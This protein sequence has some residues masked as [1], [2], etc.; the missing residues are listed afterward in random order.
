MP[1]E[2]Q[3]KSREIESQIFSN[4]QEKTIQLVAENKE[5]EKAK[6]IVRKVRQPSANS[7]KDKK[8]VCAQRNVPA[9]CFKICY[10]LCIRKL[11]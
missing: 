8:E 7:T 1:E 2:E 11:M 4:N 3:S 9:K 10:I 6:T 5:K